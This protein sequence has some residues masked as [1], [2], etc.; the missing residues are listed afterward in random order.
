MADDTM[1]NVRRQWNDWSEA[2]YRLSDIAGLHW[3]NV[4]GG[5]QARAPR[6]FVHGY[7]MCDEM[8]SGAISH[9]CQHGKGPHRIK[10]CIVKKG[11][12]AAFPAILA[13]LETGATPKAI[14]ANR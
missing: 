3:D 7:V 8:V 1:V 14:G 9:S 2:V 11:N 5:V 10:V 6:S 12:E 13:K 4:S